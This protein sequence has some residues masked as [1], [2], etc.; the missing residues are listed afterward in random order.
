MFKLLVAEDVK[1]I[2]ETLVRA[3]PWQAFG[4]TLLGAVENGEEVLAWLDHE[5]PDLILTDIGMPKMNGLELIETVKARNPDIR[6][7]ILSGLSEFEHARQALKLQVLDYVLKPIDPVEIE[8]VVLRAVE[9]LHKEREERRKLTVAEHATKVEFP[10]LSDT[11]PQ[12]EWY[13]SLKKTKLVEQAI[14]Y[15]KEEFTRR[16]LTLA[17]VAASVGLS[18]KYLNLLFKE[19]TSMT[20]NHWIIRLRMEEAGRLLKDPAIKIYEICDRIGYTD[21]D[22]FRENFK[23]Q[24]SLTPTEYRNK[25]L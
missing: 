12:G 19:I 17:D 7:I 13:G 9:V 4:I 8:R 20:I 1:T 25:F 21:Q 6:Y 3:I 24:F 15:M 2:R 10:Y 23:K 11:L 18:E 5:E 16:E 14:Q 22:H